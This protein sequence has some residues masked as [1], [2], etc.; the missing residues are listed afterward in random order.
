MSGSHA[1]IPYPVIEETTS[2]AAMA[3]AVGDR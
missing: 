3:C 1:N 2:V